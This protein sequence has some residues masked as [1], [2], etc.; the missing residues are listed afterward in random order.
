MSTIR[1]AAVW[2]FRIVGTVSW[3]YTD[4]PKTATSARAR[5]FEIEEFAALA[6]ALAASPVEP[7]GR[8]HGGVSDGLQPSA[9]VGIK[10][11]SLAVHANEMLSSGGHAFDAET[12]RSLLRDP[13]IVAYL[14]VLRPLA[15]L[16]VERTEGDTDGLPGA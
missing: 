13:E 8:R 16:P 1:E 3:T 15:L 5:G 11:A 2:R 7:H 4:D 10:L 12:I 14:D 6:A 9:S